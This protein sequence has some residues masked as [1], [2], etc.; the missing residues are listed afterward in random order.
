MATPNEIG[1]AGERAGLG[2]T[3]PFSVRKSA[4]ES[5]DVG[6]AA[7]DA[8]LSQSEGFDIPTDGSA[9]GARG[10]KRD[11]EARRDKVLGPKLIKDKVYAVLSLVPNSGSSGTGQSYENFILT[12]VGMS[13]MERYQI[14]ETFQLPIIYFMGEAPKVYDFSGVLFNMKFDG[15]DDVWRNQFL[16][17][18]NT[19]LRG[20]QCVRNKMRAFIDYDGIQVGGYVLGANVSQ[21]AN[22]QNHVLFGFKL[23]VTSVRPVPFQGDP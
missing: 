17:F 8:G 23:Y 10:V 7:S 16:A 14:V 6:G 22:D 12:N 18:Y 5:G 4:A 3:P 21:D 2:S 13:D 11:Y 15:D 9:G 19:Q 20:T 1:A